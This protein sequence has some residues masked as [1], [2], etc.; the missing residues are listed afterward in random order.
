LALVTLKA[1]GNAEEAQSSSQLSVVLCPLLVDSF[2]S[3]N[4]LLSFSDLLSVL[5]RSFVHSGG[6][7]IGCGVDGGIE[8]RIEGEDCLSQCRRDHWVAV[9]GEVDEAS[10]G[11]VVT[12][13]VLLVV[14]DNGKWEGGS[15]WRQHNFHE[16]DA[17]TL[18]GRGGDTL[19]VRWRAAAFIAGGIGHLVVVRAEVV[20]AEATV[21]E[22]VSVCVVAERTEANVGIS[23]G[24]LAWAKLNEFV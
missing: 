5:G 4:F 12:V 24:Y 21:L 13:R 7:P 1:I 9:S 8:R 11:L 16:G 3:L 6:K 10:N 15:C 23:T 2:E 22:A 14:S 19:R 18:F 20:V 17:V